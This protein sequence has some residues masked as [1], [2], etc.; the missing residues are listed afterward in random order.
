MRKVL[1]EVHLQPDG[2]P[3]DAP[4][5]ETICDS[6]IEALLP[7]QAEDDAAL[8]IARTRALAADQI[9]SWDLPAEPAVVA[10]ARAGP[11]VSSQPGGSKKS[12]SRPN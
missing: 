1:S 10:E 3:H 8:L 9:V 12:R 5:L 2:P 4:A 6:L 11:P 7:D